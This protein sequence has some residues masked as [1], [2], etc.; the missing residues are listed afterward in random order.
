MTRA[1]Y[2]DPPYLGLAKEFYGDRHAQAEDYDRVETHAALIERLS[3]EFDAWAM[4]LHTPALRTILPLCPNDVRVMAWVKP[5]ASFKPGVRVA[6]AWEPVIVRGV[7]KGTREQATT[8][9]W[10]A[11]NITLQRGFPGA[12][13]ETFCFW[14]FEV[15]NLSPDDEFHDLFPGSGAVSRAWESWRRQSR[16]PMFAGD[17]DVTQKEFATDA[18]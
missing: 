5:F 9:D 4:S 14:L 18:L 3:S 1:A 6:Y 2:A 11:A 16:L 7:P 15:L 8:R 17:S 12:K 13:P 10:C